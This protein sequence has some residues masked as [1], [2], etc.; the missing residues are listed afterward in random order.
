MLEQD[1]ITIREACGNTVRNVTASDMAGID[2]DEPFDVTPYAHGIFE[3]FLRKP[4][5]QEM[6]RKF[7][8]HFPAAKRIQHWY[9]C[10]TLA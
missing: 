1:H 9:L 8:L 6:G 4:V 10:T 3:F 2:P 7:K 5:C